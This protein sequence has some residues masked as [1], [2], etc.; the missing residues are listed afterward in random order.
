[1]VAKFIPIVLDYAKSKGG[2]AVMNIL[3]GALL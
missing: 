2:T 1:M 3:K